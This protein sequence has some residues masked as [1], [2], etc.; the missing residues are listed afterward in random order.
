MENITLPVCVLGVGAVQIIQTVIWGRKRT[1]ELVP[2]RVRS[3]S[4]VSADGANS[5]LHFLPQ[6]F[7][8]GNLVSSFH[9]I[10]ISFFLLALLLLLPL[11]QRALSQ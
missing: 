2:P 6:I 5:A 9:H 1:V 7:H 3:P 8:G 11:L 10:L 4:L